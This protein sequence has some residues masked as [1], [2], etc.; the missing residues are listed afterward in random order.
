MLVQQTVD[1]IGCAVAAF[2]VLLAEEIFAS[3]R[4]AGNEWKSSAKQVN[5]LE[6][7][8]CIRNPSILWAR[9]AL[10]RTIEGMS[11]DGS[12]LT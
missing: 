4:G 2:G 12:E 9:R 1:I 10:R 8:H 3:S 5:L 6:C 7:D 11:A